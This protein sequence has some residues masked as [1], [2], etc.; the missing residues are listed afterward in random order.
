MNITDPLGVREDMTATDISGN[1]WKSPP[2]IGAYEYSGG[3]PTITDS[4]L[5]IDRLILTPNP[6][7]HT[8]TV[9]IPSGFS[10][11]RFGIKIFSIDGKLVYDLEN[12]SGRQVLIDIPDR[13]GNGLY[14]VQACNNSKVLLKKLI[15]SK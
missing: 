1:A 4:E 12:L 3:G 15:I 11:D 5:Q 14:I 10:E 8:F 9:K 7:V 13:I 6:A 2:S